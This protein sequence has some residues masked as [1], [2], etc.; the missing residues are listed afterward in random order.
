MADHATGLVWQLRGTPYPLSFS[1]A[2]G[3]VEALNAQ[4]FQG[5]RHWRLPTVNELLSVL[6]DVAGNALFLHKPARQVV[7]WLWSC[8]RHGHHES[9]YVNM[10]MGFAGVQDITC[11]N[12]VRAVCSAK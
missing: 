4:G 8:D 10:D 9:W 6:P 1:E 7:K 12:H 3:Y 5:V 11:R 2:L